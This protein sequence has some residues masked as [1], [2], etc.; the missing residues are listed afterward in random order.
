MIP[1]YKVQWI[2]IKLTNFV[3]SENSASKRGIPQSVFASKSKT[4]SIEN[5]TT[6][7]IENLTTI[8]TRDK[9][10]ITY[11]FCRQSLKQGV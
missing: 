2:I 3:L 6:M 8:L 1:F 10:L 11:F 7:S 9:L 5:L 4:L